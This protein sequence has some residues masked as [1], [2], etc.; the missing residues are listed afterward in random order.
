M[1]LTS[2]YQ[3]S[4]FWDML[5]ADAPDLLPSIHLEAGV[6]LPPDASHGTTILS[7]KVADGVVMVGDRMATEGFHVSDRR[8]EKVFK[9]DE[10]TAIAIAGVAG[11][12]I[13][14]VRLF[15]TELEHYE[16]IE[17]ERL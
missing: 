16:K 14:V 12:C 9:A 1:P 17:G 6:E 15:Q 3:G 4:S 7:L 5:K 10:C 8:I 2:R 11:P 13:E